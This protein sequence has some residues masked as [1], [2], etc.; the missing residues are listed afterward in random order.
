MDRGAWQAIVH[1]VA[2]S[3]MTKRLSLTHSGADTHIAKN[4]HIYTDTH[5][6]IYLSFYMCVCVSVC[7]EGYP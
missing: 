2:E 3:D 7:A 5:T 1:V 4:T 6:C